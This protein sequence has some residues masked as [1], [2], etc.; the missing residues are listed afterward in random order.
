MIGCGY[1]K[2]SGKDL[3]EHFYIVTEYAKNGELFDL[4][5]VG[6]KLEVRLART[7]FK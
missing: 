4:V 5:K 7:L 3:S 6:G 1:E 2:I